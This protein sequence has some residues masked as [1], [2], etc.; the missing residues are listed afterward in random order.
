L[1]IVHEQL[2]VAQLDLETLRSLI[3][4]GDRGVHA[5]SSLTVFGQGNSTSLNAVCVHAKIHSG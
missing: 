5:T 3:L 4:Y 2:V 1:V